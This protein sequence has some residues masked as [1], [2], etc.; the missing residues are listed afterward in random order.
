[1]SATDKLHRWLDLLAALL[2]R[3]YP[4]SFADLRRDVP[5]YEL[6]DV[7]EESVLRTFERD[8]DELRD[9]GVAIETLPPDAEGV[10]TY[11]LRPGDFYLPLLSVCETAWPPQAELRQGPRATP[12]RPTG[13]GFQELPVLSLTPDEC[14]A[15]RRAAARVQGLGHPVLAADAAN[16]LRKLQFDLA[17]FATDLPAAATPA[18]DGDAFEVLGDAL[19]LRKAVRFAYHSMGRDHV[20]T[21]TV[22]PFG[23]VFLTGHW[24]LVARDLD[25]AALRQ[26]RVS[27]IRDAVMTNNRRQHPDYDIPADFDLSRHATSR[28]AWEL[29]DGDL[30]EVLVTFCGASGA[31]SQG[32][33]LGEPVVEAHAADSDDPDLARR[34]RRFRVR[35][36]DAFLRWVL[37]FAGDAR[38]VAP[39]SMVEAWRQLLADTRAAHVAGQAAADASRPLA[40][41][42][43]LTTEPRS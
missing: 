42:S 40:A 4:A 2:R 13:I 28:Q 22:E 38:P 39:P 18:T 7:K 8:K 1:M 14:F 27:R 26:F 10:V 35:R 41:S 24:Y 9:L 5:G 32:A 25:A 20:A 15:L 19:S 29:G 17:D 31:V 12:P 43:P 6:E 3:R 34:T 37:S 16:A 21:R 33:A 11:R 30:V 36:P 23:L